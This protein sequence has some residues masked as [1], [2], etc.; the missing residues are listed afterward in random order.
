MFADHLVTDPR[1]L[2]FFFL[3]SFFFSSPLFLLFLFCVV[4]V[5][6]SQSK[7]IRGQALANMVGS[8]NFRA[9]GNPK[10]ELVVPD[11]DANRFLREVC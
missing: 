7:N 8:L 11:A 4:L 6:E 3:F 9:L 5:V 1:S 2:R 10:E